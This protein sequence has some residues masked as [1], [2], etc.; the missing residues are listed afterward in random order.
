M[1]ITHRPTLTLQL[2]NFDLFRTCRTSSFCTVA[3]QLA[4]FQLK[5]RIARSLGDSWAS[6]RNYFTQHWSEWKNAA[7]QWEMSA[8]R[9]LVRATYSHA[10]VHT[11]TCIWSAR[12][13]KKSADKQI[14]RTE[15]RLLTRWETTP[16]VNLV[17]ATHATCIQMKCQR[18]SSNAIGLLYLHLRTPAPRFGSRVRVVR[19]RLGYVGLRSGLDSGAD[20]SWGK[21]LVAWLYHFMLKKRRHVHSW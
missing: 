14:T 9:F 21:Y 4:R 13:W 11:A 19:V 2:H 18:D 3:W 5:R 15:C 16:R 7:V 8:A 20:V 17:S 6:C 10:E 12:R 1:F